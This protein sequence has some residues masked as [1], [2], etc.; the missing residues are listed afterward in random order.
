[1]SARHI[2]RDP[3]LVALNKQKHLLETRK[4][5]SPADWILLAG[6]YLDQGSMMNYA[7]CMSEASKLEVRTDPDEQSAEPEFQ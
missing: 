7:Y 1:M 3:K 2:V 6:A 5:A 4:D